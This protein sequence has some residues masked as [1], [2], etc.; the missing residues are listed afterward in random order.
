M[1][2]TYKMF[3]AHKNDD[4]GHRRKWGVRGKRKILQVVVFRKPYCLSVT[5][6]LIFEDLCDFSWY[7]CSYWGFR[8]FLLIIINYYNYYYYY[9]Y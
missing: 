4:G 9:Y 5:Q 3:Q 8:V 7:S 1:F 6:L 2:V